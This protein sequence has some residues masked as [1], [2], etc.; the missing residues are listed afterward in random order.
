MI[1]CGHKVHT[2][3]RCFFE[4]WILIPRDSAIPWYFVNYLIYYALPK[5]VHIHIFIVP[6]DY[7]IWV[8]PWSVWWNG[9]PDE[10]VNR[11]YLPVT[12]RQSS[13]GVVSLF[14]V[15][16]LGNIFLWGNVNVTDE[17]V[18][19]LIFVLVFLF[20]SHKDVFNA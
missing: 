4:T 16:L 2:D 3:Q 13:I 10:A 17:R 14:Q 1:F 6:K 5:S 9:A 20:R 7:T 12:V 18:S 11:C 15:K 19:N 8:F